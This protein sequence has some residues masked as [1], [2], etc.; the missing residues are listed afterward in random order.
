MQKIWNVKKT[1]VT[2]QKQLSKELNIPSLISQLLINRNITNIQEAQ[3]FIRCS[4]SDLHDPFLLKGMPSA[5]SRIK[6]SV[7]NKEK[8]V[9]WGD[10]DV[11][12]LT[13]VALLKTVL[14]KLG[15][16]ADHYIPHRTED[17]YGLNMEAAERLVVDKVKLVI[18]VDC[19]ISGFKEVDFLRQKGVDVIIT[20]HH[21]PQGKDLPKAFSVINPFQAGCR[22]PFKYLAGVGIA[23]KLAQAITGEGLFEHIDFVALGTIS[24]IAPM[25]DE[26]R[27]FVKHGLAQLTKTKKAGLLKLLD[28]VGIKGKEITSMHAG[29]LLGPRLNATG[30]MGSSENSFKLLMAESDAEAQRLAEQLNDDNRS[31]QQLEAKTLSEALA[32]IEQEVNFKHHRVIVLYKDDWHPGV[33]GIVA[34]RIVERFYRPAI[35]LT[36]KDNGLAKGSGRSIDNFHLF[37]ALIKCGDLLEEFGGHSKACGLSIRTSRIEDFKLAINNYA[38]E[39]V[40]SQD[41]SPSLEVDA[42]IPLSLLSEELIAAIDSLAPFGNGNPRPVFATKAVSLKSRPQVLGKNTLK[43]WVS[44]GDITCQAVGFKMADSFSAPDMPEVLDI[45]Y[46]VGL[47]RWQGVTSIEL[48]LKDLRGFNDFAVLDASRANFYGA[49][50]AV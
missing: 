14:I 33:I 50:R 22:Y 28:K 12:G 18:T 29:F 4:L 23:F 32:K 24:D 16:N 47:N 43:L 34:S 13:S 5:V 42:E 36:S 39:N 3:R 38:L 9:V 21:Q 49:D 41:L 15:A 40:V 48:N 20:D 17:G 26:N 1:D 8:I 2:L 30:R 45:A 31:R 35:L 27:I 37:D 6:L 25:K 11:D 10:Y 46:T 44:D 19:G 7:Q